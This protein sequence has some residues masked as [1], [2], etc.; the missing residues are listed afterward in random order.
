MS[1]QRRGFSATAATRERHPIG[2]IGV[3][4]DQVKPTILAAAGGYGRDDGRAPSSRAAP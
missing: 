4:L 3:A 1:R 2:A